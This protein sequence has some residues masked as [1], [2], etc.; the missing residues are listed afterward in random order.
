MA[1][2]YITDEE[3]QKIIEDS[4]FEIDET[5]QNKD[6]GWESSSEERDNVSMQEEHSDKEQTSSNSENSDSD[7]DVQDDIKFISK[8]GF[9]WDLLPH[10][11]LLQSRYLKSLK[12][13]PTLIILMAKSLTSYNSIFNTLMLNTINK[14]F[15]ESVAKELRYLVKFPIFEEMVWLAIL[16]PYNEFIGYG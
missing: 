10:I 11:I 4:D 2:K 12:L 13:R 9:L 3:L 14:T 1:R 15:S 8:S 16:P 6:D 7:I 5:L